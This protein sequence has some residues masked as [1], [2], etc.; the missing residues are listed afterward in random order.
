MTEK[1][2]IRI[3]SEK[4]KQAVE[5]I[6]LVYKKLYQQFHFANIESYKQKINLAKSSTR[7]AHTE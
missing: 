7:Q 6:Q 4:L 3:W 2:S 5:E 1:K